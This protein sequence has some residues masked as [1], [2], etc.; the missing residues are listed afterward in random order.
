[1]PPLGRGHLADRVLDG[2]GKGAADVAE[3]LALQQL[4]RQARAVNGHEGRVRPPAVGVDGAGQ[5]ALAGAALPAQQDGGVAGR[6]LQ[7]QVQGLPHHRLFR[8]QVGFGNDGL[9][10]GL[11]VGHVRLQAPLPLTVTP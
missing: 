6:S 1:V 2:A 4:G 7:G 11:Q 9:D 5:H 10:L 3:Q 8:L